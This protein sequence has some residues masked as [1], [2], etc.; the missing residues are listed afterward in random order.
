M[1]KRCLALFMSLVMVFSFAAPAYAETNAIDGNTTPTSEDAGAA[2]SQGH[3]HIDTCYEEELVCTL[4]TEAHV[5]NE[6][7]C[8][9]DVTTYI[10]GMDSGEGAHSHSDSCYAEAVLTCT[11][12][13][14]AGHSHGDGCYETASEPSCGQNSGDGA[15]THD[16][17]CYT[18]KLELSCSNEEEG[19]EHSSDCYTTTSELSCGQKE[20]SGHE[21]GSGCYERVQ[22]CTQD[23]IEGHTH[24]IGCYAAPELV[25][26][27]EETDGHI[28]T[29]DCEQTSHQLICE[30]STEPHVHGAECYQ[31]TLICELGTPAEEAP[32][33]E[34]D[35]VCPG[36]DTCTIEGCQNHNPPAPVLS[37]D[38]CGAEGHTEEECTVECSICG[39]KHLDEDCAFYDP[40]TAE[41]YTEEDG[42]YTEIDGHGESAPIDV[43]DYDGQ[44][45]YILAS[46]EPQNLYF[47]H[48]TFLGIGVTYSIDDETYARLN[49]ADDNTWL[50]SGRA[51]VTVAGA[52]PADTEI[53]LT[54]DMGIFGKQ[55]VAIKVVEE[56]PEIPECNC[57][58]DGELKNHSGDCNRVKYLRYTYIVEKSAEG[59]ATD[60]AELDD[61]TKDA[62]LTFLS[63][64]NQAKHSE[65][66][67]LIRE[68]VMS[69]DG[70]VGIRG[71]LP[72][73]AIVN[74]GVPDDET[75]T[76][77]MDEIFPDMGE[78]FSW[79]EFFDISIESNGA[80]WQPGEK[81]TV[82]LD[83]TDIQDDEEVKVYHILD[84]EAAIQRAIENG[85]AKSYTDENENTVYYTVL[86]S[87]DDEI[88]V[89]DDGTISFETDSFSIFIV[90][91]YNDLSQKEL[92]SPNSTI[93]MKRGDV[94]Y[95][96]W[97]PTAGTTNTG[98]GT[99]TIE[100]GDKYVDFEVYNS[101]LSAFDPG[102][103][104]TRYQYYW[105][106]LTAKEPSGTEKA[107]IQ[108]EYATTGNDG[109]GDNYIRVQEY[110]Y[111]QVL[112]TDD[113]LYIDDQV[114]ENG[115]LVPTFTNTIDTEGFTYEWTR[116]DGVDVNSV[117][118]V[119][120]YA[121][122]DGAVNI[123][124]DRGGV[125]AEDIN[126]SSPMKT[127]T[128]TVKNGETVIATA[129]YT[130][131]YGNELLNGSFEYPNS[132][133]VTHDY[134][135]GAPGLYWKTTS[136]SVRDNDI[137]QDIE[138]ISVGN[139]A[140]NRTAIES[141]YGIS[142][143]VAGKTFTGQKLT[144]DDVEPDYNFPDGVQCA[145]INCDA[146]GALYQDILTYP[147]TSMYWQL[148]HRGRNYAGTSAKDGGAWL[149]DGFSYTR[150]YSDKTTTLTDQKDYM[151]VIAAPTEQVEHIKTQTQLN[152][153]IR[154]A[155]YPVDD[156]TLQKPTTQ[157]SFDANGKEVTYKGITFKIWEVATDHT[158]WKQYTS[159][160]AYEVADGEYLTRF[161]FAAGSTSYDR[162]VVAKGGSANYS[163]GNFIDKVSFSDAMPWQIEYYKDGVLQTTLTESGRVQL[164]RDTMRYPLNKT[165]YYN[166]TN[167]TALNGTT[168][169]K[170]EIN[171]RP[172]TG[173]TLG[174]VY[175]NHNI[176]QLYFE[177]Y[178]VTVTK[179]V[180]ISN[181]ADLSDAE[182]DA[183]K[184]VLSGYTVPFELYE[185]GEL[186][187]LVANATVT[188]DL[189]NFASELYGTATFV[190]TQGNKFEPD[191]NKTYV[192]KE[193]DL[194]NVDGLDLITKAADSGALKGSRVY[195]HT[196][197]NVY[198]MV[199]YGDLTISKSGA[200]PIDENQ[201]F[202]F[203][204][205]SPGGFSLDVV[206]VGNDSTTIKHL[207]LGTYSVQ[208]L[209]D[210][211]WRYD[212]VTC[213]PTHGSVT[214]TAAN[215]SQ[216][217]SFKNTRT[218]RFWL[219]GDCYVENWWFTTDSI[220]KR[221]G[222]DNEID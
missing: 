45:I 39:E 93:T 154:A 54:A 124:M 27:L 76:E 14:I 215:R 205:T 167:C 5:H 64:D 144:Y 199:Q 191:P 38:I 67:G 197:T 114:A 140:S 37:C 107:T 70:T 108:F 117:A 217:V 23:E 131:P 181:F 198:E 58:S 148:H 13:E 152:E 84:D 208:E 120:P 147:G 145:E 109:D 16:E 184:N 53:T 36:D 112:E 156:F 141:L 194:P 119:F 12:E 130:V 143:L 15:H 121:I 6:S 56:I 92:L 177:S 89:N 10:C 170:T 100:A 72:D 146:P 139:H 155:G 95:F 41:V 135:N 101:N 86:S 218:D 211:S 46:D 22:T 99:W 30:L 137:C 192:I 175:T 11:Q 123:A 75:M 132:V 61:E 52:V 203:R 81:V 43:E 47:E 55:S 220:K 59:I 118:L 20:S 165:A 169:V 178:G 142:K 68:P 163:G 49:D 219:S 97:E 189:S 26:D 213:D 126:S 164:S 153:L 2:E 33:V 115:C 48:R 151:Y 158:A 168:F 87:E 195:A 111:V 94:Q 65:L 201:S 122:R 160:S 50:G 183:L 7:E 28:H 96:K 196:A 31:K 80:K 200:D 159:S 136:E 193:G 88:T 173:T 116:D 83:T 182:K 1:K 172:Y 9:G 157:Y 166:S 66:V 129:E 179:D 171:G 106:R 133:N 214:L 3:T 35:P 216:T 186:Q 149:P 32:P 113:A 34:A 102:R 21:H 85:S 187:G 25:C 73:D 222:S 110:F 128:V 74:V 125:D 212:E 19:H 185:V 79:V 8:Y 138:I 190:D 174:E 105:L 60:W 42:V 18:E 127:Y 90:N 78:Y 91:G 82:T 210:W 161:F 40:V 77:I 104:D 134:P 24:G 62:I 206:V 51:L 209:S 188:I 180:E 207:P 98:R 103:N 4:P 221:D 63:W 162:A 17:S 44:T 71:N 69:K 202:L 29:S 204:V 176:L 150:T 57:N